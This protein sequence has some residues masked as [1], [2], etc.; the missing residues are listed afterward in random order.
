MPERLSVLNPF[1]LTCRV[2]RLDARLTNTKS[3]SEFVKTS[4][5]RVPRVSLNSVSVPGIFHSS[6]ERNDR[7]LC[8]DG[9]REDATRSPRRPTLRKW[10]VRECAPS[11]AATEGRAA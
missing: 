5:V 4:L 7:A 2:Y 3:P 8:R 6:R 1:R 11:L 10:F 9:E